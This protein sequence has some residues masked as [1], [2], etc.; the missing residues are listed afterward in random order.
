MA[1]EGLPSAS[2]DAVRSSSCNRPGKGR[3]GKLRTAPASGP[4]GSERGR[5]RGQAELR[6]GL[7]TKTFALQ[8]D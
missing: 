8:G 7:N 2:G 4:G 6:L 5:S 1:V 3:S